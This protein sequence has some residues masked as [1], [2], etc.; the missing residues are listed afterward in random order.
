MAETGDWLAWWRRDISIEFMLLW[1][2]GIETLQ[3]P[4]PLTVLFPGPGPRLRQTQAN[5]QRISFENI[6]I[7]INTRQLSSKS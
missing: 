2:S 4:L 1:W 6:T 3:I 7:S 5:H